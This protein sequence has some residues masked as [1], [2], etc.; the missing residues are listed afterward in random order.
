[1]LTSRRVAILLV[2]I[3]GFGATLTGLGDR[4]A[5]GL[6]SFADGFESGTLSAWTTSS[7]LAVQ[8]AVV[9]SGARAVRST[10]SVAWASKTLGSSTGDVEVALAF[11]FGS[12]QDPVWLTRLRTASNANLVRVFVNK[13]GRIVY[14]NHVTNVTRTSTTTVSNLVW[15]QLRIIAT[16]AGTS[17]HVRVVL[18]GS[19]VPGLDRVES[20]GTVPVGKERLIEILKNRAGEAASTIQEAVLEAVKA[21]EGGGAQNDDITVVVAKILP[22]T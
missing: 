13:G 18:D 16:I 15:H 9:A 21:F 14:R 12:R 6:T 4:T 11:R 7:G 19:T 17:S 1:M 5:I 2:A 3:L 22:K 10:G 8:T 20:L